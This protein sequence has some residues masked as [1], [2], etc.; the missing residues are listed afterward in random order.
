MSGSV[1]VRE[2]M[3][4][5]WVRPGA[6]LWFPVE[7]WERREKGKGEERERIFPDWSIMS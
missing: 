5:D 6:F 3:R 7:W 2:G 1:R 4:D